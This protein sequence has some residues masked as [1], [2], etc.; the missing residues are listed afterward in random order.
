MAA[1]RTQRAAGTK[2][3]SSMSV[4][5]GDAIQEGFDMQEETSTPITIK[6]FMDHSASF[7]FAILTATKRTPTRFR[8][9][10]ARMF[11][12]VVVLFEAPVVSGSEILPF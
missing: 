4:D 9:G 5:H 3:S 12:I 7:S 2:L 1:F 10:D 11:A 8:R 6:E